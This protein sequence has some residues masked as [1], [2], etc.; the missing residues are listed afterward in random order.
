MISYVFPK[1]KEQLDRS[2]TKILGVVLNKVDMSD[3]KLL[4]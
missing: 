4:R 2:D 3:H 1:V